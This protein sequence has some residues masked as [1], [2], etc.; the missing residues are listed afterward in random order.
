[1]EADDDCALGLLLFKR[2]MLRPTKGEKDDPYFFDASLS[3]A[4]TK[5][6]RVLRNVLRHGYKK[7]RG[8]EECD[9]EAIYQF[10]KYCRAEKEDNVY[11]IR[12]P[13]VEAIRRGE[14][15]IN[16]PTDSQG[17]PSDKIPLPDNSS[18][19]SSLR[20]SHL[21]F[22][23]WRKEVDDQEDSFF[24]ASGFNLTKEDF[25]RAMTRLSLWQID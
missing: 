6:M 19:F 17:N 13:I 16:L 18:D 9:I 8:I 3:D 1:M 20:Q 25:E 5:E 10:C 7:L 14:Y 24:N 15:D 12:L 23:K 2:M 21:R 22:E 4:S 11:D